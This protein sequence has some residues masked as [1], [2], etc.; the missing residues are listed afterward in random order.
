MMSKL[1]IEQLCQNPLMDNKTVR[2]NGIVKIIPLKKDEARNER[3][4]TPNGE[5]K[6][7]PLNQESEEL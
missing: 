5:E 2:F 6:F 7:L 1:W 4:P 3:N